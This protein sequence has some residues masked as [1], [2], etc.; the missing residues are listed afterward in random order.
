MSRIYKAPTVTK[1]Q[2][3]PSTSQQMGTASNTLAP[4]KTSKSK[5]D[6]IDAIL[7]DVRQKKMQL[8][9]AQMNYEKE[10][11]AGKTSGEPPANREAKKDWELVEE[12]DDDDDD[13]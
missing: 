9:K 12:R 5:T 11:Q 10:E 1:T 2:W 8:Q 6:E 7:E 13:E 4:P 3:T